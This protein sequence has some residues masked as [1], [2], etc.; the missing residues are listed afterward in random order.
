MNIYI[1]ENGNAQYK[2]VDQR[3]M[4][5]DWTQERKNETIYVLSST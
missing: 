1:K 4:I 5:F 3:H 2:E